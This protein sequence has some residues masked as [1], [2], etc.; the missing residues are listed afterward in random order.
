MIYEPS[1]DDIRIAEAREL[2]RRTSRRTWTTCFSTGRKWQEG[3]L[4][5]GIKEG[6]WTIWHENGVISLAGVYHRGRRQGPWVSWF[7]GGKKQAEF[8]YENGRLMQLRLQ[9]L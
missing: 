9:T 5:G 6:L 3:K 8:N 4:I 7:A 1:E 2:S